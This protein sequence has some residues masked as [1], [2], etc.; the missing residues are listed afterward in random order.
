MKTP[1][2]GREASEKNWNGVKELTQARAPCQSW[3]GAP[4]LVLQTS[5][6]LPIMQ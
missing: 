2:V 5:S 1:E 4:T 6:L 3:H